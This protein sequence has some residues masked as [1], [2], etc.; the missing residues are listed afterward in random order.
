MAH[1]ELLALQGVYPHNFTYHPVLTKSW[2]GDWPFTTGRIIQIRENSEGESMVD[3]GALLNVCP[4]VHQHHV[5]FCGNK[6]ARDQLLQGL[7]RYSLEPPSFRAEV[8]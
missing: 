3:L 7:K 6:V 8:W 5:R 1:E 4:H 2:P